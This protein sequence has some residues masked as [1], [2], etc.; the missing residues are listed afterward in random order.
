MPPTAI[1]CGSSVRRQPAEGNGNVRNTPTRNIAIYGDKIYVTT[2]DARLIALNARNGE[3]G[4]GHAGDRSEAGLH[5]HGGC[6]R[7]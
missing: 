6:A 4:V 5:V 3:R 1:S 7:R 2:G